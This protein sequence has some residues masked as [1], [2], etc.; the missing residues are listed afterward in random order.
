[1]EGSRGTEKLE[2]VVASKRLELAMAVPGDKGSGQAVVDLMIVE[3][4][5]AG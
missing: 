3:E 2:A 4:D 1:M 5:V